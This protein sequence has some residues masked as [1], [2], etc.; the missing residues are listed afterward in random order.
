MNKKTTKVACLLSLVGVFSLTSCSG[1]SNNT[2][3][4][5]KPLVG[6]A[7]DYSN[8][9]NWMFFDNNDR[10]DHSVDV[11]FLYPT[12][13]SSEV[14]TDVCSSID[15][16]RLNA[17]RSYIQ[18]AETLSSFTNMYAP[19]YRQVSGVG[20]AKN[21]TADGL[22]EMAANNV[23]RTDVYA[24]LD[25]YFAN[26][27]K[28]KPFILAGHSQGSCNLKIV[29]SEYM[30]VHPEY[31]KRMVAC[32]AIGY[33]FPDSWFKE[34]PLIKKAT[35]ETDTG[36]LITWNTE[37]P[38]QT[39]FNLPVGNNDGFC[40]NPLNWKVDETAADIT[41]NKGSIFVDSNAAASIYQFIKYTEEQKLAD[42][43]L[44]DEIKKS[45]ILSEIIKRIV[46]TSTDGVADAKID[47][48]RGALVTTKYT[49]Y[50]PDNPVFGDKSCH[51]EDWSLFTINIRENALKRINAFL[52]K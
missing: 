49:N 44:L 2:S 31:L 24:S 16:M 10:V 47:L 39:K 8:K 34:N 23:T 32:Y 6:E 36:V 7:W 30:K 15:D 9:D 26:C 48:K 46:S 45:K 19:Y 28:G 29:L 50:I 21:P 51:F 5:I 12:S 20:I 33:Y 18:A 13:V 41:E 37:G 25:Y 14:T 35:G 17:H 40:I 42:K 43:K 3:I 1:N 38:G 11:F 4:T 22:M 52:K 27:N